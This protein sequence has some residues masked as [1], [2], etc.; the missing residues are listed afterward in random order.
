MC[1]G[2]LTADT[3]PRFTVALLVLGVLF[4]C[5]GDVTGPN[6]RRIGPAGGTAILANGAVRLTVPAGALAEEIWFTVTPALSVPASDLHVSGSSWEI[7]PPGTRFS[8]AATL[9]LSYN[10][11][12]VP[13]G[14]GEAGLG[15]FKV[16]ESDW[17][18]MANTASN[19]G[20][21]TASGE[22]TSLG[23]Y[24]V[25]GLEVASISLTPTT[26][27]LQPGRT[28]RLSATPRASDGRAL[29]DRTVEWTSGDEDV[30][31]VDATGLVTAVAEGAAVITASCGGFSAEANLTVTIP[32][33]RVEVNPA[34][35][36][37]NLGQTVQLT[38]EV[39]AA[40]GTVLSGRTV[41]WSSSDETVAKV[42]ES[43]LVTPLSVGS[44][45]I[46]AV[47]EGRHG[48]S[49][50]G[51]HSDLSVATNTLAS[52]VVGEAYGQTLAANGGDGTYTWRLTEGIL[53]PGLSLGEST[54]EIGGTP[55]LSGTFTFTVGVA[56]GSQA[57]S[58][59]L[60]IDVSPVPVASV[61]IIPASVTLT[62]GENRQFLATAKDANGNLIADRPAIW[63]S[64]D[65]SVV[66]V[67][68][69]GLVTALNV[70]STTI[71]ATVGGQVGWATVGV[72]SLLTLS[73]SELP[74]AVLDVPYSQPLGA[75][76]GDGQYTWEV[77]AGILP[78]GLTLGGSSGLISGVPSA[79]GIYNFVVE[80]ASSDGQ[81]ASAGFTLVVQG[82]L[83]ITTTTLGEAAVTEAY[84]ETLGAVG[85][86]QPY[87]WVVSEDTL[88]AGLRLDE[89]SGEIAGLPEFEGASTFT[90]RVTSSDGQAA[91]A[92]FTITVQAVPVASVNVT[93]STATVT[94]GQTQAF[95]ATLRD[96]A[97]N[98]LTGRSIV[99]SSSDQSV[100]TVTQDGVV[101]G[102][103]VGSSTIMAIAGNH[104]DMGN[105]TVYGV[106]GVLTGTLADGTSGS[107]Y[108]QTL[109]AT[110]GNG[111]YT[112][113]LSSGA[114]PDGLSLHDG[115]GVISGTPTTPGTSNF[116]VQVTSGAQ[117]ASR[118]LSITI[119]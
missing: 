52:G 38:A 30:A 20:T 15:V 108:N 48:T 101:T 103:A 76:G 51:I 61:E 117:T 21:N 1:Q 78:P 100:A 72:N 105:L 42:S 12:S 31:A 68:G 87:I 23:R 86:E 57:A 33:A 3:G 7:G 28:V 88:P 37:V 66:S 116:T 34:S 82:V 5:D 17:S 64:S 40:D 46:T 55:L 104:S 35:V 113:S 73:E 27:D 60:S 106:L 119:G 94:V 22:V 89:S 83:T 115:T 80:V 41:T 111:T 14:I 110:G 16:A 98:E 81:T 6:A 109:A 39:K 45:T 67:S 63:A 56:S 97:G 62:P 4:A 96:A 118:A 93:P 19:P 74:D 84:S 10:P 102:V 91:T 112:W 50:I 114:L 25:G 79:A 95:T 58:K 11:G 59:E 2:F 92:Q 18:L 9:T 47:S 75:S 77:S 53:P 29:V 49:T 36:L 13:D 71:T 65:V 99:W 8:M 85:G 90:V 43:G 24:G 107:A 44:A 69:T 32:V 26:A 54:G 70:G